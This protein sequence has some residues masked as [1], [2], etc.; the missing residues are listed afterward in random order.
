MTNNLILTE[1]RAP[2]I[3]S[4]LPS[5]CA[6]RDRVRNMDG[7]KQYLKNRPISHY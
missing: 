4:D 2:Q 5:L 7:I 6:L 1:E 3:L